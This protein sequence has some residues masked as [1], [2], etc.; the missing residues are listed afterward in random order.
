MGLL[1]KKIHCPCT[2]HS[3]GWLAQI[4]WDRSRHWSCF[5]FL[6]SL[7]PLTQLVPH[8]ALLEKLT[9]IGLKQVYLINW[10]ASYLTGQKQQVVVNGS[11]LNFS[12]I[13]NIQHASSVRVRP[14][15]VSTVAI[16]CRLKTCYVCRRYYGIDQFFFFLQL[17]LSKVKFRHLQY[18]VWD[19]M[20][21]Y[22]NISNTRLR[23]GLL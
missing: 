12:Q 10:V 1:C 16:D 13:N 22:I 5:F 23:I 11:C 19:W 4:T 2:S 6:I 3:Y 14:F 17:I 21:N 8:R 18:C 20:A 7:K 15:T 9:S